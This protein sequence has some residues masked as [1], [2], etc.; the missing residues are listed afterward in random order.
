MTGLDNFMLFKLFIVNLICSNKNK[1]MKKILIAFG[2]LDF[3]SF[4][5]ACKNMPYLFDNY[6]GFSFLNLILIAATFSLL[7]SGVF[8][9]LMKKAA[10]KIYYFQLPVRF[11]LSIFTVGFLFNLFN[12]LNTSPPYYMLIAVIVCFEIMRLFITVKIQRIYFKKIN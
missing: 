5:N 11:L 9:I 12:Y 8:S 1:K 10:V 6:F 4:Y 7:A 2:I 3:Y